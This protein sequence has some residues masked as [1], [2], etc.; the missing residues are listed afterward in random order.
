MSTRRQHLN[1]PNRQSRKR[2]RR[3][4]STNTESSTRSVV[5]KEGGTTRHK[6]EAL[7]VKPREHNT[8]RG[9]DLTARNA[10]IADKW[11]LSVSIWCLRTQKMEHQ[12]TRAKWVAKRGTNGWK[13][14]IW[15]KTAVSRSKRRHP[16]DR[17]RVSAPSP[18]AA[19]RPVGALTVFFYITD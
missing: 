15:C 16:G 13:R 17:T 2:Q 19:P 10:C 9:R 3:N 8:I 6:R 5:Y 18:G 11:V 4:Q 12:C 7:L 1:H 14:S